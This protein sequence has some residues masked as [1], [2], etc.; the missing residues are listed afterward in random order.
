LVDW[1]IARG[2]GDVKTESYSYP[3]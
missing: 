1:S 3:N 2:K